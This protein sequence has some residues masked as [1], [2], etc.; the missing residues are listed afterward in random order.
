MF[1]KVLLPSCIPFGWEI[2]LKD[3][4]INSG[5]L[6]GLKVQIQHLDEKQ[7]CRVLRASMLTKVDHWKVIH[8]TGRVWWKVIIRSD[9][10]LQDL[11]SW[12]SPSNRAGSHSLQNPRHHPVFRQL[13]TFG[14][15]R[16]IGAELFTCYLAFN[17]HGCF[18]AAKVYWKE[19][20]AS[21]YAIITPI[22]SNQRLGE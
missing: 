14:P 4:W 22:K 12:G 11:N 2:F 9:G 18:F 16:S 3:P 10:F 6:Q 7:C 5:Q 17:P 1:V 13:G 19:W 15:R 21:I 20:H 8:R